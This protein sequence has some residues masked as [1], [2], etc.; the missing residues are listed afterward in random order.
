MSRHE[1]MSRAACR[2]Y[3]TELFFTD[4]QGVAA[5]RKVQGALSVCARCPVVRQCQDW[6]DLYPRTVGVFGGKEYRSRKEPSDEV[7]AA[8][9]ERNRV[10]QRARRDAAKASA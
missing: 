4:T 8:R 5:Q 10:Q 9:R 6:A 1:W 7:A 3:S 2:G